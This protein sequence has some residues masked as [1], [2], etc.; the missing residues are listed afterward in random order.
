MRACVRLRACVRTCTCSARACVCIHVCI[1][2]LRAVNTAAAMRAVNV[3]DS[4]HRIEWVHYGKCN[5]TTMSTTLRNTPWALRT[6]SLGRLGI[7]KAKAA[8]LAD[9]LATH[10]HIELGI[11]KA[12]GSKVDLLYPIA[13]AHGFVN[14]SGRRHHHP[15]RC[16]SRAAYL[17]TAVLS[18]AAAAD[19]SVSCFVK[20]CHA[21]GV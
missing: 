10:M 20:V 6:V 17:D 5:S 19:A 8:L 1:A 7:A 3:A 16:A 21:K 2:S 11:A 12:L 14:T 15:P 13:L 9:R 4:N 18:P